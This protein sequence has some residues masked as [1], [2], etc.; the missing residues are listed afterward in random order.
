[1]NFDHAAAELRY[2]R[3]ERDLHAELDRCKSPDEVA[4]LLC[5]LV[6]C[7]V[8][9]TLPNR[10]VR[11]KESVQELLEEVTV[12]WASRHWEAVEAW[13]ERQRENAA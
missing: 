1:M 2:E 11:A 6:E 9:G 4:D 7:H 8:G 3:I 5:E 13:Y 10:A 12:D